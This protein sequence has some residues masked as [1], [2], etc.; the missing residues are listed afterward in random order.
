MQPITR[1]EAIK[2]GGCLLASTTAC[3]LPPVLMSGCSNREV[4]PEVVARVMQNTQPAAANDIRL[5]LV[6]DNI[7]LRKDLRNDWGFAC[8][9][10]GLDKTVLFDSGRYDNI[11]MSNLATLQIDPQ[12]IDL[13]FLSHDHPDHIGGTLKLLEV[14]NHM[15]IALVQTFPYGFK[16]RVTTSGAALAAVD[17]PCQLTRQCLSTGE[18]KSVIKNEHALV[19]LTDKGLIIITGCAHP[20]VVAMTERAITLTNREV[21]LLVGGF[22]LLMDD[23][24]SI[25]RKTKRL[26]E[27]GVKYVAPSHCTGSEAT[28]IIAEAYQERFIRSGVG[29]VIAASELI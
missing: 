10:E 6:Y 8:L 14:H 17:Q 19:I 27:L 20:G 3:W 11:F 15:Q 24:A 9:I 12:Q 21:L 16:K 23:S 4:D 26:Q 29:R 28:Q 7:P 22:H 18:M 5:T 1:R 25:R 2:Q 13:L